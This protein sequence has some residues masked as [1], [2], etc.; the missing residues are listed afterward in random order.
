[1]VEI[2]HLLAE[3][4]TLAAHRQS[5]PGGLWGGF[6]GTPNKQELRHQLNLEQEGLCIYC[7]SELDLEE[8]HV[9]HIKSKTLSPPLTFV[10]DNLSHSCDGP[11][12][13]GHHKQRGILPIEPRPNSNNFFALSALTGDISPSIGLS[14]ADHEKVK[15]TLLMLGLNSDT[16]LKRRR[17]QFAFTL[18]AFS[19]AADVAAF[20]SNAP[21]RW[22]LKCL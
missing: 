5:N 7:E 19:T 12:H 6:P 13:C 22:S 14:T 1:M 16:G 15:S 20:L 9:E 8:G 2:G 3:P 21:F 18:Q 10:Y 4:L 11:R 17:Q